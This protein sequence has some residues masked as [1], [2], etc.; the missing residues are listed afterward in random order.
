MS[1]ISEITQ[2]IS[3]EQARHVAM[4]KLLRTLRKEFPE[5]R[6]SDNCFLAVVGAVG[7]ARRGLLPTDLSDSAV[8]RFIKQYGAKI[9]AP[10]ARLDPTAFAQASIELIQSSR[11]PDF[12][13]FIEV[14]G[15][16]L[17]K[18]ISPF[19]ISAGL[20][21]SLAA[22]WFRQ[23]SIKTLSTKKQ[24]LVDGHR[25]RADLDDMTQLT[26]WFT[27]SWIA[28]FLIDDSV[29]NFPEAVFLDP[30]CGAGHLL[31]PALRKLLTL[32]KQ[33]ATNDALGEILEKQLFALDVD[34]QLVDLAKLSLYLE[35]RDG[36]DIVELP[37]ANIHSFEGSEEAR[38]IGSL[39]LASAPS[40][41][42]IE[43]TFNST[44]GKIRPLPKQ[45]DA[46]AMNPPYL[47]HRTMPP[48]IRDFLKQEFPH[49]QY[50]LYAAFLELGLRLLKP[51]GK[52]SAICQQSV[53]TIQ[54]YESL[55]QTMIQ[56]AD[57]KTVAQLGSGSFATKSGE[58]TSTA[59][60]TLRK[61]RE[62]SIN[63][64]EAGSGNDVRCWQ[65]LTKKDK[66]I[67]ESGGIE[68]LPVTTIARAEADTLARILPQS[69]FAFWAPQEI[70]TLFSTYAPITDAANG[71]A[72][73]NGLFTCNNKKFVERFDNISQENRHEYVPYDKGGGH[74]WY[75]TSPLMLLWKGDGQEIRDYRIKRGQSAKLPGEQHYFKSGVTYSYIGTRGFKA[76]LLTPNSVF[77]IASSAV[78][79]EHI[80]IMF[81]LGFLNS[82]LVRSILGVLNPTVNFQIGDIRR[83]PF[84]TPPAEIERAVSILTSRA[85]AIAREMETFDAS[86]PCY[87]GGLNDRYGTETSES[88][89]THS[90]LCEDWA[91][92][93]TSIQ[94]QLDE[95][96]F[97]L[98]KIS[99]SCRK[100]ILKDPWV[101]RGTD[102]FRKAAFSTI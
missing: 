73:T 23:C 39:Q 1:T 7:L 98:Y 33:T 57:V 97:D 48:A 70:L 76:R 43:S 89:R 87:L 96:I 2:P 77:D 99:S 21:E 63:D 53:L 81:I 54:R 41:T 68:Q 12:E 20:D 35:I 13:S 4:M 28:N 34:R 19:H 46:I 62:G 64:V 47:G 25:T 14:G 59:I 26:Q 61:H 22:G 29:E 95:I 24:L 52:L 100:T 58:K 31:I 85:V 3:L 45:F 49:S 67:A 50:D 92:E 9:G 86:S 65:L 30:A 83:L 15:E 5:L 37:I 72:C 56:T 32:K 16:R 79:S 74:K 27:P 93:E 11:S 84:K 78:F 55:R 36:A 101:S 8:A 40:S 18:V 82:S 42:M 71:I 38:A 60:I 90:K 66:L 102:A 75:R 80:N 91:R 51:G 44:G 94:N 6:N 69:P 10:S 88:L 17:V